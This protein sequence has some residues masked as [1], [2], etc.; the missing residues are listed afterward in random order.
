MESLFFE[1][2]DQINVSQAALK[3]VKAELAQAE[4]F[5]QGLIST[6]A[7]V[8]R[9]RMERLQS[10]DDAFQLGYSQG[11]Q[12]FEKESYSSIQSVIEAYMR[13]D[14]KGIM[15]G[16]ECEIDGLSSRII[17][18]RWARNFGITQNQLDHFTL[19]YGKATKDCWEKI[20]AQVMA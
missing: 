3:C 16:N 13:N 1:Y 6:D 11:V 2:K 5:A 18:E 20:K 7:I 12:H 14:A 19:G 17:F 4:K 15:D 8:Q 9:L 10:E